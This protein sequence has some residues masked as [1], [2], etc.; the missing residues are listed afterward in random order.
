MI[1]LVLVLSLVFHLSPSLADDEGAEIP[2]PLERRVDFETEVR[3]L[4]TARRP[5]RHDPDKQKGGPRLDRESAAFEGGDEV[6]FKP[7][8]HGSPTEARDPRATILHLL[9]IDHTRPTVRDNGVDRRLA[10]VLGRVIK[11]LPA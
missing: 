11:E 9:G 8:D 2:P 1:R 3:P 7:V 6:G 5:A 4:L 10:D